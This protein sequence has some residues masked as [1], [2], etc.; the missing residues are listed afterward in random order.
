M[1]TV[2]ANPEVVPTNSTTYDIAPCNFEGTF[3]HPCFWILVGITGALAVQYLLA[4]VQ[5]RSNNG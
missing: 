4:S 1:D 3:R 2:D 5:R